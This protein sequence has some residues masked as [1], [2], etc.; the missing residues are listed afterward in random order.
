MPLKFLEF[1]LAGA[2]WVVVA[3]L[4]GDPNMIKVVESGE[5]PH[6][7]T[8]HLISRAPKYLVEK[9]NKFV[10]SATDPHLIEELRRVHTPELFDGDFFLPRTMSIRQAGKKSNHGLNYDMRHRRFAL[11]NEMPEK[12]AER[13]VDLYRNQAY[14][15][16]VEWHTEIREELRT[17]RSLTN[18]M[19]RKIRLFDQA[20]PELWNKAYSFKPQGTVADICLQG[21]CAAYEDDHAIMVDLDLNAQVHDSILFQYP[22]DD[23]DRLREFAW[24]VKM[25][26]SPLLEARGRKFRLGVDCKIGSNWGE[27]E[28]LDLGEPPSW[29]CKALE[30]AA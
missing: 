22:D 1:D 3:Y 2:E 21:M 7:A 13:I 28:K 26:M 17:T 12:D 4:S 10:G 19:G 27:M 15:G 16:L 11:E 14:P 6:V 18:L 30:I 8:G 20:G 25:H 24:R 5:S 29:F 9:E 23:M